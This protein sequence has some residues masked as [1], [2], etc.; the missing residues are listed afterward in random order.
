[1]SQNNN[2]LQQIG[3]EAATQATG[4]IIGAGMGLLL[5]KSN[6]KRQIRQQQKLTD[7]QI[8]AN[9]QMGI[10]NTQQQMQ[11]WR[12]TN[13]KPQMEELRKAGLNPGLIY[14]MGGSGGATIGNPGGAGVSGAQAPQGGGEIMGMMMNKAQIDLIKAQTANIQADTVNKP[15]TGAN[16]EASTQSLTQGI[17]NQKAIEKLTQVQTEIE[18]VKARITKA[19]EYEQE[20]V[21]R[22]QMRKTGEEVNQLLNQNYINR[23]NAENAITIT[24]VQLAG[25]I[26]QNQAT[27]TGITKTEAET[28][29]IAVELQQKWK[30]LDIKTFEA[31]TKRMYPGISETGGNILQQIFNAIDDTLGT[32]KQRRV[33]YKVN[34]TNQ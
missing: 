15:K 2:L 13:Y 32:N 7:M 17:Q 23:A 21:I 14:G 34:E 33:P 18:E 16:I 24:G 31:E 9:K 1:M 10:F 19:T 5:Q 22:N 26:L 29:K 11:M 3:E 27:K 28:H 4:G 12:D 30:E 8:A 25:A 20:G 6:D